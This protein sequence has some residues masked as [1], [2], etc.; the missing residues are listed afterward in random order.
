MAADLDRLTHFAARVE[1]I[2]ANL[3]QRELARF[4]DQMAKEMR[5]SNAQRIKANVTPE[6]DQMDPRKPQRGNREIKFIYTTSD[7]EVRHLKSWRGTRSY[8]IGFDIMR[9]GIRTFKRS[10]I[11]RF[12][13]VDAS[14]GDATNKSKIKRKMFSRLIKSKWLKAKGYND[15]AEVYFASTAEKVAHIHHYGLKDKGS[16]GQDIQYPE[17]PLLGMDA[18]DIDKVEDLLL[19]QLTKGL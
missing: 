19:A 1:L 5:E 18:K 4:A 12:I 8:I 13:K 14:K 3:S 9:G 2:R 16:K 11:K 6:G 7:N 17:R 10:R 15:R